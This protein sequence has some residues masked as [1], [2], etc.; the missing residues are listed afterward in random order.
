M[1]TATFRS[2]EPRSESVRVNDKIMPPFGKQKETK[3]PSCTLP[4]SR[5]QMCAQTHKPKAAESRGNCQ[6]RVCLQLSALQMSCQV[7]QIMWVRT[8]VRAVARNKVLI[9]ESLCSSSICCVPKPY[10]T[11]EQDCDET[12]KRRT[13][14]RTTTI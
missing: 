7:K 2:S 11:E 4:L 5:I 3:M 9:S 12:W 10:R 1:A 13:K 14:G 8:K 6:G